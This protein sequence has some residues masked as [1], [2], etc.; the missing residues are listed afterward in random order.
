MVTLTPE[1]MKL[2]SIEL[3]RRD[4][5]HYCHVKDEKFFKYDRQYLQ[6]MAKGL[7]DFMEGDE[8]VLI[9][10]VPPRHGKSYSLTKF[11]EWLLGVDNTKKIMTG[12]YNEKLST[13]FAKA[14]RNSISET[15][16]DDNITVYQDIFPNSK[17]KRG[18]GASNLWA[19]E[20]QYNTYL[21]T[22]P[23]GTATGF[24][25]SVII[26]DDL[27]KNAYEASNAN[28]LEGHWEWFTNTM[29][30]RLETG[31]KIIIVMT[32][33][34][35]KDLAGMALKE[36]PEMGFKIKHINMKAK[37]DDGTMLCE[38]ILSEHDYGLRV[39]AMG[40]DIASANYQQEP[41]DLVGRLYG[42][43]KEY[44]ELPSVIYATNAYID[45]ADTGSDYLA[46]FI[47]S[48]DAHDDIYVRDIIYMEDPMEVTEPIVA[49]SLNT[50]NVDTAVIESNNGGRGFARNVQRLLTEMGNRHTDI[51][52]FHQSKN[53]EA[54][55]K[56][57][58]TTV[59]RKVHMPEG[60]R[61]KFPEA[62]EFFLGY[63]RKGKNAHDDLADA[64]TGVVEKDAVEESSV[65]HAPPIHG[66]RSYNA[67][68]Y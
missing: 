24:G 61:F 1:I 6:V 16:A 39:K 35:S 53:K 7:Q 37:Q 63:Q 48:V 9:V 33:W 41:I 17:I 38:E 20:G 34:S 21:A 46:G 27:I 65:V 49:R 5:F 29:L 44:S 54:R 51:S 28:I 18:D 57:N 62:Y 8:D 12:S 52:P 32:R 23:T 36:F 13:N 55:I 58:A 2:A 68:N 11:V 14:V 60:W 43:F 19:L 15:K 4:F 31:G 30:S 10:N 3:A 45:T 67:N 59:M 40:A 47:Y 64:I 56:S 66:R 25:A 42:D 50:Y 22:S 26:V